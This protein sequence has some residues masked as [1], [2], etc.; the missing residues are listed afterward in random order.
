M[1]NSQVIGYLGGDAKVQTK[2]GRQF[3]TA[4]ISHSER[5]TDQAGQVH[6]KTQWIDVVWNDIPKFLEYL[7]TG[8]LLFIEGP[9]DTRVYPSEKDRC[10]KAGV[11]IRARVTEFIGGKQDAVPARLQDDNGV[12]HRVVKFYHTDAPGQILKTGNGRQFGV[13]DNGWVIPLEQ[14]LELANQQPQET[15]Q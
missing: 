12:I 15:Q 1:F 4:K 9:Q 2:D 5:W 11:T 14:A 6:E 13:D 3:T 10:M 7:K 8:T